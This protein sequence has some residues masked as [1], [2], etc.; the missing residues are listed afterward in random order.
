[1]S[2]IINYFSAK[3]SLIEI[4][5]TIESLGGENSCSNL[6]LAQKD[7]TEIEVSFFRGKCLSEIIMTLL[8]VG[9]L[10]TSYGVY[11]GI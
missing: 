5:K 2:S 11:D 7:I 9:L 10:V 3:K 8:F 1:M 6:I 4:N